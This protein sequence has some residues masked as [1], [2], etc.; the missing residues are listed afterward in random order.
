MS[1]FTKTLLALVAFAGVFMGSAS[2]S[3]AGG[4]LP[5]SLL[6]YPVYLSDG[7][8]TTCINIT[9]TWDAPTYNPNTN[10]D[11]VLDVHFI[12]IDGHYWT[13]F[14]RFERLTPNDTFS[15]LASDHNP[16]SEYGFLYCI[17][18]DPV[19]QQPVD[20]DYLVGDELVLDSS[21]GAF[22]QINAWAFSGVS[23]DGNPTDVNGNGR[24]DLDG[25]EYEQ[26]ADKMILASFIGD[27]V[28]SGLKPYL[29]LVSL[30]CSSD[31]ESTL[32]FQVYNNNEQEFSATHKIRC[33]DIVRLAD[34][35]NVFTETFLQTT[36]NANE[37]AAQT[38]WAR[39]DGDR[40]VDIV[41]NE[42]MVNDPPFLGAHF[43]TSF[44]G[45]LLHETKD[46]NSTDGCLDALL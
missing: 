27:Y 35:D 3:F 21:N 7:S 39:I 26:V 44:F 41:G 1:K 28:P 17:A 18:L 6:V 14:N 13:E 46:R 22:Y 33:W 15:T 9:N 12:Y 38:G 45:H 43:T 23:G 5:G 32:D 19:S 36:Q 42:P 8:G 37:L 34:I 24:L 29:V 4:R 2:E 16:N 40:A 25:S 11:G 10:L 30:L 31:F 20:R